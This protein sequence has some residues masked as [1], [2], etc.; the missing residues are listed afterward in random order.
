M[1]KALV[2]THLVGYKSQRETLV[3]Y[4]FHLETRQSAFASDLLCETY[5]AVVFDT[6]HVEGLDT[7]VADFQRE[8]QTLVSARELTMTH[9][10]SL[11]RDH[12]QV[13]SQYQKQSIDC[14]VKAV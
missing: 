12:V 14:I 1:Q 5:E 11:I 10:K 13:F 9:I 6:F 8:G 7:L 3:S 4:S 2:L